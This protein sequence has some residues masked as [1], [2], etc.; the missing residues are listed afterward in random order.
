[1]NAINP[2]NT[3]MTQTTIKTK[4]KSYRRAGSLPFAQFDRQ[5]V[6][7]W[8]REYR[9]TAKVR[10]YRHSD[11]SRSYQFDEITEHGF[12]ANPYTIAVA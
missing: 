12:C 9:R 10:R 2:M 5:K 11:G 6:A 3:Q 4:R 7:E 8:V 1:M